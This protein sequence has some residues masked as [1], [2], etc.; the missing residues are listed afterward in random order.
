MARIRGERAPAAS[1]DGEP[2]AGRHAGPATRLLAASVL[3]AACHVA[4]LL[5]AR[6]LYSDVAFY[7]RVLAPVHYLLACGCGDA[8]RVAVDQRDV[9]VRWGWR[10]SGWCGWPPLR[11]R[12]PVNSCR[13]PPASGWITRTSMSGGGPRSG[14]F[15]RMRAGEPIYTNE[16]AKIF[17]HLN[18]DSRSLPWIL[19]ADTVQ[20]LEGALRARPGR[21]GVVHGRDGRQ[22]R[23]RGSAPAGVNAGQA[24]GRSAAARSRPGFGRRGLGVG[25]ARYSVT[26]AAD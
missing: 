25:P 7:D 26:H 3:L 12:R 15:G 4:A 5:A 21:R 20:A 1:A 17:F 18:R 22:L 19:D 14:G 6:L 10:R 24:G 16:P 23:G 8:D 13:S 9:A 2:G 11:P